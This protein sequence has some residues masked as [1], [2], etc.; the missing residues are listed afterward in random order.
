MAYSK[1]N[2][3]FVDVLWQSL[4]CCS[5]PK[6]SQISNRFLTASRSSRLYTTRN[7]S[8][9][10]YNEIKAI[11]SNTGN[12]RK[13]GCHCLDS[14]QTMRPHSRYKYTNRFFSNRKIS[15]KMQHNYSKLDNA[16]TINN[17]D[18]E[19]S[20][21]L[22]Y[23]AHMNYAR[24]K[25]TYDH[26]DMLEFVNAIE[27][28]NMLAKTSPGFVWAFDNPVEKNNENKFHNDTQNWNDYV[29]QQREMV[30]MLRDDPMLMPQMS[31]WTDVQSL[32]H[33]AF[34]SGHAMYYKRRREWFTDELPAPY[35]V[36]WWYRNNQHSFSS[37]Q[38]HNSN[39]SLPDTTLL[40]P[41]LFDAFERCERLRQHGPTKDAF[42]FASAKSFPMPTE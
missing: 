23:L 20:R 38:T 30:P 21:P 34:K 6:R 14:D 4:K 29:T 27:P 33:F 17:Y 31:L 26:P 10:T 15:E 37:A 3:M 8:G 19:N 35:A 36:C 12:N 2:C 24:L 40:Y 9:Y 25:H 22:Y 16:K 13:L 39:V 41:T 1:S 11:V 28:V 18:N 42:D 5:S 7:N 32:R